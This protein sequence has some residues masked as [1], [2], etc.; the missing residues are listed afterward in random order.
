MFY[1]SAS[2]SEK[3]DR[4]TVLCSTVLPPLQRS[5]TGPQ[6]YVLLFCLLFREARQDHSPMFYCSAS[7]SEK[8]DRT[9]VLCSTVL[10]PLQRS[11]TGPQ[12][13]V[14]QL[15]PLL[16][17]ARQDHSLMFYSSAPSS[18]KQLTSSGP[19]EQLTLQ[20]Q[21]WNNG[22][23]L[24]KTTAVIQTTDHLRQSH[25]ETQRKILATS[26]FLVSWDVTHSRCRSK[27]TARTT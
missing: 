8:Q 19:T 24:L 4:T 11:K 25:A 18:D 2:S 3:Q 15:C 17:E 1:C 9:T 20:E 23:D 7:S 6:S 26:T 13:Y 16:R 12:S 5:K 10:P 22:E 14:L 21:L 27:M